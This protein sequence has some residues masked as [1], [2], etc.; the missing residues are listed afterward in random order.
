[1]VVIDSRYGRGVVD[2]DG[3]QD[4]L[5]VT[6]NRIDSELNVVNYHA[7]L[8]RLPTRSSK[9][10][11]SVCNSNPHPMASLEDTSVEELRRQLSAEDGLDDRQV[12][13]TIALKRG[14][15]RDELADWFDVS[16]DI[17]DDWIEQAVAQTEAVDEHEPRTVATTAQRSEPEP[18][19]ADQDAVVEYLDYQVLSEFGWSLDDEDLFEKADE[20]DLDEADH[21]TLWVAGDESIL[22]AAESDG[23]VWPFSCRGGACANCAAV[24][25]QGAVH[26]PANQI[27]PPEAVQE[28]DVRL[29]CI[30]RPASTEIKL[31]YNAKHLDHLEDILLPPQ[32]VSDADNG[33][34]SGTLD[35][36]VR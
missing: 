30:G 11:L 3:E 36:Q 15:P 13:T 18:L 20:A 14:V 10:E 28:R 1:M 5:D 16:G 22:A 29:T 23:F 8:A 26:M 34:S 27:L 35:S 2:I 9:P 19:G 31:V 7:L 24:C 12:M 17:V 33:R 32:E 4:Y 6:E 21:G 25:K